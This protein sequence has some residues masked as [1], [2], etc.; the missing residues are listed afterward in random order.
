MFA[1]PAVLLVGVLAVL[2]FE[3]PQHFAAAPAAE[4]APPAA[5]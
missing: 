2:F 5:H 1:L 3:R 4:P